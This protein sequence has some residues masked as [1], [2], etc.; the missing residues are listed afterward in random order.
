MKVWLVAALALAVVAPV[1]ADDGE[2]KKVRKIQ[3]KKTV[4]CADGEDCEERVS[5][6]VFVG[7]DGDVRVLHDGDHEWV[8]EENV[9]IL[10]ADGHDVILIEDHDGGD[11]EVGERVRRRMHRVMKRLGDSGARLHGRHGGGAFLGVQLSELTPELR[12]HFGVPD[13]AGVM[14]GKVVDDSPALRAGLEVGDIVT[15]VGG[16]PVASASAL[17]RAIRGHEDGDTVVLEVW[18]DGRVQKIDATLEEREREVAMAI[19]PSVHAVAS[20]ADGEARVI[21]VKVAC[22]DG[23][24]CTVDVANANSFEF[25]ASAC[26]DSGECE[27]NVDCDGGD[28]ACTVNGEATDCSELGL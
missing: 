4:D 22:E 12:T 25:A 2:E 27:V 6:M 28:C 15:A 21:E 19:A 26:G 3:I 7:D 13:D 18:R 5:R 11:G 24:D 8:S 23:E 17:S 9:R 14:V 10:E 1:V 16:E 20:A